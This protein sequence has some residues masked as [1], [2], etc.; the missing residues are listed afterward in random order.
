MWVL[1][2][3]FKNHLV[4]LGYKAAADESLVKPHEKIT[5]RIHLPGMLLVVGEDDFAIFW[6]GHRM[7]GT[8]HF[9][10]HVLCKFAGLKKGCC[11]VLRRIVSSEHSALIQ[12][13]AKEVVQN[14]CHKCVFFRFAR[15]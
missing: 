9:F 14:F 3:Q 8:Y 5:V 13:N 2:A 6:Y 10:C 11:F 4:L 15:L 7:T 12:D 1:A